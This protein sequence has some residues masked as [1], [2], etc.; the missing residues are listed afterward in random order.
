MP[1]SVKHF[2]M[3]NCQMPSHLPEFQEH[4]AVLIRTT[5]IHYSPSITVFLFF[6]FSLE[7]SV[8]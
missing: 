8:T 6:F 5:L 2:L 4:R 3:F 7:I 1:V